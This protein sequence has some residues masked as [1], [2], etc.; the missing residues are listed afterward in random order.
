MITA[1]TTITREGTPIVALRAPSIGLPARTHP[2][3]ARRMI[4]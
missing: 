2:Y 4:R 3:Q 1:F